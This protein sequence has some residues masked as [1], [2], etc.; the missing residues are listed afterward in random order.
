MRFGVHI[1]IAGGLT[2]AAERAG[3]LGC[4]AMQIFARNPRGWRPAPLPLP[5]AAGFVRT[6]AAA[7]IHPV[8][9]HAPYLVN[10]A[11]P[12]G[13]IYERS[14]GA[15]VEDLR[16]CRPLGASCVITHIGS[17]TGRGE[18]YGLKR[19]PAALKRIFGEDRGGAMLLLERLG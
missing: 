11:S 5:Q 19:N 14:I 6:T 4:T 15:I 8:V 1:S 10:L 2:R 12:D 17:H 3:A 16:R 18:E 13:G 9:V 7:G